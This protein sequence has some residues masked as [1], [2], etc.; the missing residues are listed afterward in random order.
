MT[1]KIIVFIAFIISVN[2]YSQ[3]ISGSPYSFF[4]LGD[5]GTNKTI[6]EMGMGGIGIAF[7][8]FNELNFN[9]PAASSNLRLTNFSIS[10]QSRSYTFKDTNASQKT[11]ITR[12]SYVALGFPITKNS[13]FSFGLQPNTTV[14]Y[15]IIDKNIDIA[16][17]L[18][19]ATFYTGTGGTNKVFFNYGYTFF[20]KLSIGFGGEYFFGN[21]ENNIVNQIANVQL[22][23]KYKTKTL[24]KGGTAQIGVQ[25]KDSISDKLVLNLGATAKLQHDL[26]TEGN[27]YLYSLYYINGFESPRDTIVS[28]SL[29]GAYTNPTKFS[30]GAGIGQP[31]KWYAG[32]N[33]TFQNAISY[34]G[35]NVS[36]N[37]NINF[38]KSSILSLG[39]FYI[40]K[41]NSISSYWQRVTYRAGLKMEKTGLQV[42]TSS[43]G[44][45]FN[46][47]DDFGMSFGVGLPVGKNFSKLNIGF[48]L[49]KRGTT[50]FG[51][52]QE[53]YYNLRLGLSLSDKWFRKRKID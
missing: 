52:V 42:N 27:Q 21:T 26:K 29:K 46:S 7:S 35:N 11:S 50:D 43:S 16:G 33:Y 47:I 20:K 14:G 13:G 5:K 6:E 53:N 18:L 51:L 15:A 12:L 9:N 37:A 48:E 32:L 24:V 40:P 1:K 8:G 25:Y 34:A 38:E 10:G 39:G 3:T 23:T 17:D 41:I 45:D 44:G 2:A 19:A 31:F 49:G 30:I 4:G 22:A 36:T 28:K